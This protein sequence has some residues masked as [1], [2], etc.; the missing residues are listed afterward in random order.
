MNPKERQQKLKADRE[1]RKDERLKEF[2]ANLAT[3]DWARAER[4]LSGL[5]RDF[6]KDKG[7]IQ[8]RDQLNDARQAV[9]EETVVREIVE[10]ESLVHA[11]KWDNARRRALL[12]IEGFP[13]SADAQVLKQRVEH[14]YQFYRETAVR[15]MIKDIRAETDRRNWQGAL[16]C[17][18]ELVAFYPEHQLVE[19]VA[20]QIPT[21]QANLEIEQRQGIEIR[22]QELIRDGRIEQAIELAEDTIH[23]YPNSPQA[24]SLEKLLPRIRDLATRGVNEFSGFGHEAVNPFRSQG[25]IDHE[26][27]EEPHDTVEGELEDSIDE[28]RNDQHPV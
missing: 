19:A 20:A 2:A 3:R 1:H 11:G 7:V 18:H 24:A 22:L 25:V 13:G 21:M 14:E 15:A 4:L 12:L 8:A 17:A 5:E 26:N 10:I 9:E 6:A 23:R 27:L 16:E 28:K